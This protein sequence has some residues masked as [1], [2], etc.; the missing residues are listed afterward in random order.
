MKM[1]EIAQ[2][3]GEVHQASLAKVGELVEKNPHETVSIIRQ[4][5]ND[6]EAK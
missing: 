4:W 3:K 2:I 6:A 1:I 5:L